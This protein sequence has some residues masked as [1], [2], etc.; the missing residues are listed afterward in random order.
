MEYLSVAAARDL[1][2]LRLVLTQGMP[3][4][5]AEAI[6][7][8][9][10]YK[11]IDYIAVSQHAGEANEELNAWTGQSSAPVAV[12]DQEAALSSWLDQLLLAERLQPDRPLLPK[13]LEQRALVI[14][15]SRE[16]AG[17]RGLGWNRRLQFLT[18]MMRS[19]KTPP[20]IQRMANKY[21]WSEAEFE[22]SE[23]R[24]IDCLDYFKVRL[25]TQAHLQSDYLVGAGATAVDFYLANF[26]GMFRPLPETLNPMPE[27]LRRLYSQQI[28]A[29]EPALGAELFQ[30]R[31]MM[32]QR[33]I[34]TP[35]QF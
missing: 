11:H 4:P 34:S 8:I 19:Q 2:G 20:S 12:L 13:D 29:L 7:S 35:L 30:H 26:M 18:P 24:I 23:A 10:A 5:W 21:G 17:E 15:L 22:A 16:V 6:K 32:Y 3:G 14:G 27:V 28:P 1:K 31:D 25:R 33:H 9:F